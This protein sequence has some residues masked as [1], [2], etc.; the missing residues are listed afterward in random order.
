M[1]AVDGRNTTDDWQTHAGR[2]CVWPVGSFEQ[3]SSHLPLCAD[4]VE[5]TYFA[6][7]LAEELGAALLPA[8]PVGTSLEMTGFRGTF[9]LTPEVLM[10]I[11]RN[12]ADEAES[13]GFTVMIVLNGHGGNHSLVPVI[14]DINRSNRDIKI[15]LVNFW[16]YCDPALHNRASDVP[17]FHAGEWET[18]VMLAIAPKLV[19]EPAQ[20]LQKNDTDPCPLDQPDLTTFGIGHI[21]SHGATGHPSKATEARG[22]KIVDSIKERMLLHARDRLL[23]L[24]RQPRYSG[25]GG[26]AIRNLAEADIPDAMRLKNIAGWNQL[27][28]DWST[29]LADSPQHTLAA[30]HNG[31][32]IGTAAAMTYA[33]RLAWIGMVLVDPEF[34]GQ[35]IAT[36]LVNTVLESLPSCASIK[37]DATP[38]GSRVYAKSGFEPEYEIC[39]MICMSAHAPGSPVASR[40]LTSKSVGNLGELDAEAFGADRMPLLKRLQILAPGSAQCCGSDAKSVDAFCLGRPGMN[41]HHVGPLVA[42]D[43]EQAK[44]VMSGVL[45]DLA[46]KPVAVDVPKDQAEF[47]AWLRAVG[48]GVHRTFTRMYLRENAPGT[49]SMCFATA[50][51]E[52]G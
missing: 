35:G 1:K 45:L 22:R 27:E 48:F 41:F 14:R 20:D 43:V 18:S 46:G 38:T 50:G 15:L 9:T 11:V 30:V 26:I 23:K 42:R 44:Q 24:E 2:V 13:Q 28:S 5:A 40:R 31:R 36:R 21:S 51:P 37:L 6:E 49:P 10:Q 25:S 4:T 47:L 7:Y 17:D 39:R 12:M 32:V 33:D 19:R 8:L 16:E 52:F 3:H 29:F 34:R